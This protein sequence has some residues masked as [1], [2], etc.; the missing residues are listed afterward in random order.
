MIPH[1]DES[2]AKTNGLGRPHAQALATPHVP[3]LATPPVQQS[4]F[5]TPDPGNSTG[6]RQLTQSCCVGDSRIPEIRGV[7]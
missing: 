7:V 3:T 2:H 5:C 4:T 6:C 1:C